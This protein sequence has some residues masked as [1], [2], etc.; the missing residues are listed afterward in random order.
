MNVEASA[1]PKA[2]LGLDLAV[3]AASPVETGVPGSGVHDCARGRSGVPDC[4]DV[5]GGQES[6][7]STSRR[8]APLL[9]VLVAI[10]AAVVNHTEAVLVLV[11]VIAGSSQGLSKSQSTP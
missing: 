4:R 5:F 10:D 7:G 8:E 2:C 11:A 6:E 1:Q 3:P 9:S